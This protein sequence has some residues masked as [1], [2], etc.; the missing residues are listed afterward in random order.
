MKL[1]G[2][3]DRLVSKEERMERDKRRSETN[4]PGEG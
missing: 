1:F 3:F 2:F 4:A